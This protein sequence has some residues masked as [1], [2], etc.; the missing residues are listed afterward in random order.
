MY[1]WLSSIT[2]ITSA[3]S[4][5]KFGLRTGNRCVISANMYDKSKLSWED[6]M[7]YRDFIDHL[8][9]GAVSNVSFQANGMLVSF[10]GDGWTNSFIVQDKRRPF[11]AD[12]LLRD[13]LSKVGVEPTYQMHS[14]GS[15]WVFLL[16]LLPSLMWAVIPI[17]AS[18]FAQELW[19]RNT[20]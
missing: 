2:P 6:S 14:T 10:V 16:A 3:S 7:I 11:H 17:H 18:G 8:R 19:I 5:V 1:F 20:P 9:D 15:A 12:P 4:V 13:E